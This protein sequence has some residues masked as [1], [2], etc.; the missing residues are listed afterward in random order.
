[1][2]LSPGAI[3]AK[4]LGKDFAVRGRL[5]DQPTTEDPTYSD[6]VHLIA[7][8][9]FAECNANPAK[10]DKKQTETI[11]ELFFLLSILDT[12][13]SHL[14]RIDGLI[15]TTAAVFLALDS[16]V[17]DFTQAV[18]N[19]VAILSV[20]SM[21]TSIFV[22][23]VDWNFY[24]HIE[25]FHNKDHDSVKYNFNT[26]KEVKNLILVLNSRRRLYQTSWLLTTLSICLVFV[27]IISYAA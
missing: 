7:A 15:L 8:E 21:F 24:R 9:F 11:K 4:F 23:S 2:L 3:V 19:S 16:S 20:L 27:F 18:L 6:H 26:E 22:I 13:A 5:T 12:K 10:F 14:L 1:M 25:F 17:G